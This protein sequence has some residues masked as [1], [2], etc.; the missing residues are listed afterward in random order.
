MSIYFSYILIY[1]G[2]SANK[3]T[4][5]SG[6]TSIVGG[7]LII[8]DNKFIT[9]LGFLCFHLFAI[10]DMCDGEVARYN[11]ESSI[12][13]HFLD[14]YMHY[15]TSFAMLFGLFVN[16]IDYLN[17]DLLLI[18]GL[19]A[20][21]IPILDKSIT[22]AGWTVIIWTRLRKFN[23]NLKI[24]PSKI[25]QTIKP[26]PYLLKRIS[27]IL[28]HPFMEHWIKLSLLLLALMD[29]FLYF[30]NIP[31]IE[32]KL[33]FLTYIGLAGPIYLYWKIKKLFEEHSLNDGYNRVFI[34]KKNPKL[35]DDDFL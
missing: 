12:S 32:Y 7:I 33:I 30:L 4:L 29:L 5:I 20:I 11:Q 14:W 15:L 25:K 28:L 19:I 31:F 34:S 2:L 35:P 17:N 21:A 10:L 23:E 8:S 1:L 3:V 6:L 16:S 27:F 13:G 18:I 24:T 9:L 22:S 26:K